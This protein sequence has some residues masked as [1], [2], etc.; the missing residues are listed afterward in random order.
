MLNIGIPYQPIAQEIVALV[1]QYGNTPEALLVQLVTIKYPI[2]LG[3]SKRIRR[4]RGYRLR[5]IW[6]L[7]YDVLYLVLQWYLLVTH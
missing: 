3:L 4:K 2:S 5:R 6:I 7:I 1:Q